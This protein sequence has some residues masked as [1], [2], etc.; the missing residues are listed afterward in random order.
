MGREA[1]TTNLAPKALGPYS[2]ACRFAGSQVLYLSGQVPVDPNS[3]QLVSGSA[4]FQ[5]ERCMNNLRAVLE[6]AGLSFD[7]VIHCTIYLTNIGTL[8]EVSRVYGKFFKN[9]PPARSGIQV[10]ALPLG[11]DVEID[12][13]AMG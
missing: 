9:P 11:A 8:G 1:I 5:T 7:N 2:Q 3:G 13:I 12:A 4:G 6:A 10:A